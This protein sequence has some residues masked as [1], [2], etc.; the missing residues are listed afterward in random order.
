M[1]DNNYFI[2]VF[3]I[4]NF[5]KKF[6]GFIKYSLIQPRT[7]LIPLQNIKISLNCLS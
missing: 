1:L 6:F 3:F 2:R 5:E 7:S 4:E